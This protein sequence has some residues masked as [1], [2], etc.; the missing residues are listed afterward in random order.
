MQSILLSQKGRALECE[1]IVEAR[2]VLGLLDQ[3][4]DSYAKHLLV[5]IVAV[6]SKLC[7]KK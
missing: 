2:K 6:L 7:R 4:I 5:S 1:E 3:R